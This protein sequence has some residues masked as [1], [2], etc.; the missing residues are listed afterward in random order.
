MSGSDEGETSVAAPAEE[1]VVSHT[2]RRGQRHVGYVMPDRKVCMVG[3]F[4][5]QAQSRREVYG[6]LVTEWPASGQIWG[7][8]QVHWAPGAMD[9]RVF[10]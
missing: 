6:Q 7:P 3:L 9:T 4:G 8:G 10:V 2:G 1:E 5:S